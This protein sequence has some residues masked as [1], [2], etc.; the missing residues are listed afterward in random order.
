MKHQGLINL[1]T[2]STLF[3]KVLTVG[4]GVSS[5]GVSGMGLGWCLLSLVSNPPQKEVQKIESNRVLER[6]V[7]KQKKK[8]KPKPKK[9]RVRRRQLSTP[10][11]NLST[12]LSQLGSGVPLFAIQGADLSMN[13]LLKEGDQD[14][15]ELVMSAE[16]VDQMPKPLGQC[17]PR[18]TRSMI[19]SQKVGWVKVKLLIN[20]RG[21]LDD[22]QILDSQ[23][24]G[25]Y[26]QAVIEA[27]QG[28]RWKPALYKGRPSALQTYK[29]FRFQKG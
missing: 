15:K 29:T 22:L 17:Q 20:A 3:Q 11:P 2:K 19:Q 7:K 16:T 27:M 25:T 21:Q 26:D 4:M 24:Q 23:P 6:V 14:G 1:Q 10:K 18:L 13:S 8:A 28:C 5:L 12:D 9:Q